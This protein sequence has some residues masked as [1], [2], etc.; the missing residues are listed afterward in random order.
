[1]SFGM[2]IPKVN[3]YK[4]TYQI[5]SYTHKHTHTLSLSPSHT[6]FYVSQDISTITKNLKLHFKLNT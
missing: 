6:H 4:Q 3:I 1:M 2:T 5:T